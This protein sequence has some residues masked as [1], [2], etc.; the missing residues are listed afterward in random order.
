MFAFRYWDVSIEMPVLYT[1]DATQLANA[2]NG[3][4]CRMIIGWVVGALSILLSLLHSIFGALWV[5]RR[6][7]LLYTSD[8]ADE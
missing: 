4:R 8:A 7:C 3:K 1:E 6:L 5:K 2:L